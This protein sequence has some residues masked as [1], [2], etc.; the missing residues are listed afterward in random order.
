MSVG[1][2]ALN[3][4]PKLVVCRIYEMREGEE[5]DNG[6]LLRSDLRKF[7]GWN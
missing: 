4:I 2:E 3:L 7:L 1:S 5:E 6:K